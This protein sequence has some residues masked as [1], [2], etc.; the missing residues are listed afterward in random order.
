MSKTLADFQSMPNILSAASYWQISLNLATK[1]G[2]MMLSH[3]LAAASDRPPTQL[4][5]SMTPT[6]NNWMADSSVYSQTGGCTEQQNLTIFPQW[7]AKFPEVASGIWQNFPHKIVGWQF[8]LTLRDTTLQ[9]FN[10]AVWETR[11][12][13]GLK[14]PAPTITKQSL[15]W[16]QSNLQ[17]VWK[18]WNNW[19]AEQKP[20]SVSEGV[21]RV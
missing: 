5:L 9:S 11:K 21:S 15:L 10:T 1:S 19:S 4:S 3:L 8:V 20:K 2:L 6:L 13:S 17:W 16:T 12:A 7:A 14:I 18:V